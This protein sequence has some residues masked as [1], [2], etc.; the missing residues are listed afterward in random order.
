MSVYWCKLLN[1]MH[2]KDNKKCR[3]FYRGIFHG[4]GEL[5]LLVRVTKPNFEPTSVGGQTEWQLYHF[6]SYGENFT[7]L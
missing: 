7:I 6:R 5:K 4:W 3:D 1:L 2:Q